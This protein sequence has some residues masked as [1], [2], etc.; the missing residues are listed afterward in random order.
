MHASLKPATTR[1]QSEVLKKLGLLSESD[2]T[3]QSYLEEEILMDVMQ[4]LDPRVTPDQ[5]VEVNIINIQ[6]IIY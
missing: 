5:N 3:N 1:C 4:E 2:L 6:Y